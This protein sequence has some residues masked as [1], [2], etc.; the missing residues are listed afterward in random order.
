MTTIYEVFEILLHFL[1]KRSSLF[2]LMK[3]LREIFLTT[4]GSSRKFTQ[5]DGFCT[6][7]LWLQIYI[8]TFGCKYILEIKTVMD[9]NGLEVELKLTERCTTLPNESHVNIT[10]YKSLASLLQVGPWHHLL[11]S[12]TWTMHTLTIKKH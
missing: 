2:I 9:W 12:L 1:C 6:C 8:C 5:T 4:G 7:C 11:Y 3:L 10:F